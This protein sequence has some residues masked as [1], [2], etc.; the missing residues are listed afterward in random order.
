[1]KINSSDVKSQTKARLW[2]VFKR[3]L[4]VIL[5]ILAVLHTISYFAFLISKPLSRHYAEQRVHKIFSNPETTLA[6]N[7]EVGVLFSQYHERYNEIRWTHSLF[8]DFPQLGSLKPT[9]LAVVIHKEDGD[10][11]THIELTSVERFPGYSL[12]I[13][14]E[15]NIPTNSFLVK[16]IAGNVYRYYRGGE[17]QD[18][19]EGNGE[20]GIQGESR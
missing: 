5:I 6:F 9:S 4:L 7:R 8:E 19:T 18:R 12:I 14:P 15:D 20:R 3:L 2:K 13:F 1:M 17:L 16:H 11:P 10:S